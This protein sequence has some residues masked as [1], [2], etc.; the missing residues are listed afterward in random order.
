MT[1]PGTSSRT[2]GFSSDPLRPVVVEGEAHLAQAQRVGEFLEPRRPSS[3]EPSWIGVLQ[4]GS[5]DMGETGVNE[6]E[7]ASS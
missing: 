7:A 1:C 6:D 5:H 3:F 2:S 4:G